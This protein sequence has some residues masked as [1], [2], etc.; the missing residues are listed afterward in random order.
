[1]K[2]FLLTDAPDPAGCYRITGNDY[3]Y[4]ARVRRLKIGAEFHA[5]TPDGTAVRLRVREIDDSCI[6]TESIFIDQKP[7]ELPR[8]L[9]FQALPK[10][11]AMDMIVRQAAE[12][13]VVEIFPFISGFSVPKESE[14]KVERWSRII[15]AARQQSGSPV[16]TKIH[17]PASFSGMLNRWN[18]IQTRYNSSVGLLLDPES[19]EK[20]P[21]HH[22][23]TPVP[24]CVVLAVG[25]EGGFSPA[26]SKQFRDAG[27]HP[28]RLGNTILRADTASVAAVAVVRLILLESPTLSY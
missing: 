22:Y 6:T 11:A 27:F 5:V 26:E 24:D 16:P 23:L 3:H 25:P 28:A 8:I 17:D 14:G 10:S 4:L 15:K 19:A 13:G 9:L 21:F 7:E 20:D 18:D 12:A 1:M 2:H